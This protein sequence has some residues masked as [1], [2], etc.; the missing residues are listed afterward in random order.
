MA[1]HT[2]VDLTQSFGIRPVKKAQRKYSPDDFARLCT[3]LQERGIGLRSDSEASQRL[4]DLRLMY[5]PFVEALAN[6]LIVDLPELN[7]VPDRV[8]DWQTSAWDHF[9]A[10]SPRTLDRAMRRG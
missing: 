2:A 3:T 5:E 7:I 8:D 4:K 9:L 6:Y 10:A 1:R